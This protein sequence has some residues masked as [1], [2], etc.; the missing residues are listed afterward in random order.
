MFPSLETLRSPLLAHARVLLKPTSQMSLCAGSGAQSSCIFTP[1]QP[2]IVPAQWQSS[3]ALLSLPTVSLSKT[4]C[5]ATRSHICWGF[6]NRRSFNRHMSPH[7]Q[8]TFQIAFSFSFMIRIFCLVQQ[9]KRENQPK[10]PNFEYS[11]TNNLN[12]LGF[13]ALEKM[14]KP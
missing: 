9:A 11:L 8:S 10:Y 3:C 1:H 4:S 5:P 2:K 14:I 7:V 12:S 6:P 13:I